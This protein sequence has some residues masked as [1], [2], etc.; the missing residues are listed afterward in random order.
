MSYVI[1]HLHDTLY[2]RAHM[3]KGYYK[4]PETFK[5]ERAAK[6]A[7]T[8]AVKKNPELKRE[9]FGIAE[10]KHFH[11]EIERTKT[12]YNRISG[13]EHP[14]PMRI[15]VNTPLCCDPSSETYH[16]M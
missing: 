5:A 15:P 10:A 8:R 11:A 12:V 4:F 14:H 6:A 2:L 7:L 3:K 1:Y 16:S 13:G 9:D